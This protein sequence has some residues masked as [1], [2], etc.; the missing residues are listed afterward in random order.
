MKK[1]YLFALVLLAA[2]VFLPQVHAA[3]C[4]PDPDR[5]NCVWYDGG[6]YFFDNDCDCVLFEMD[7]CPYVY[8]PVEGGEGQPDGDGDGIGDACEEPEENLP[9]VIDMD[10]IYL[11]CIETQEID[12][13]AYDHEN[14]PLTWDV[15][16]DSDPQN[17]IM[18]LH[19]PWRVRSN[20][21]SGDAYIRVFVSDG[22]NPPV[23]ERLRVHVVCDVNAPPEAYQDLFVTLQCDDVHKRIDLNDYIRDPEYVTLQ[24][25]VGTPIPSGIVRKDTDSYNNIVYLTALNEGAAHFS[26]RASDGVNTEPFAMDVEVLAC[27]EASA[28]TIIFNDRLLACSQSHPVRLRDI[29]SDE[30]D[31]VEQMMGAGR[32]QVTYS[33]QYVHRQDDYVYNVVH[34]G[35]VPGGALP[36]SV[37]IRATNSRGKMTE[38][39]AT[40]TFDNCRPDLVIP[41]AVYDCGED[42]RVDSLHDYVTDEDPH[43]VTIAVDGYDA[44]RIT[45]P[46][47]VGD[48]LTF[49]TKTAGETGISFGLR[50]GEGKPNTA[51]FRFRVRE[52]AEPDNDPPEWISLDVPELECGGHG[53]VI[54]MAGNVRDDR[55]EFQ[56]LIFRASSDNPTRIRVTPAIIRPN[57]RDPAVAIFRIEHVGSNSASAH[58]V[59]TADDGIGRSSSIEKQVSVTCLA[60]NQPPT[61]DVSPDHLDLSCNGRDSFDIITGDPENDH[62]YVAVSETDPDNVIDYRWE[63][64][65]VDVI[66]RGRNGHASIIVRANDR[67]GGH[68]DVVKT[69]PVTVSGCGGGNNAPVW[70]QFT[71]PQISCGGQ[72]D[73]TIEPYMVSDETPFNRLR[74]SVES[75]DPD[76]TVEKIDDLTYRFFHVSG[77]SDSGYFRFTAIDEQGLSGTADK[78]VVA[79]CGFENHDPVLEYINPLHVS[80]NG[81]GTFDLFATDEDHDGLTFHVSQA[82][83]S[84]YVD[85]TFPYQQENRVRV[86]ALGRENTV[87][88]PVRVDD[89][90]GGSDSQDVYVYITCVSPP[91]NERPVWSPFTLQDISCEGEREIDIKPYVSDD[92]DSDSALRFFAESSRSDVRVTHDTQGVFVIEHVGD[93]DTSA[94]ITFRA[95]DT[96]GLDAFTTKSIQVSGCEDDDDEEDDI[97]LDIPDQS[98]CYGDRFAVVDLDDHVDYSWGD[99]D[100]SVSGEDDLDVHIDSRN[101]LEVDYPEGFIGSETLRFRVED[102]EDNVDSQDVRFRVRDCG[103]DILPPPIGP[104][105]FIPTIRF[106]EFKPTPEPNT[107]CIIQDRLTGR[108]LPD[109]DCDD[110][111]DDRDN[112]PDTPNTNQK[113]LNKNGIGDA[114]DLILSYFEVVPDW[115]R[116]GESF[117]VKVGIRNKFG[118]DLEDVK[119]TLRLEGLG[120]TQ[121][122]NIPSLMSGETEDLDFLVDISECT[123]AKTYTVKLS[124]DSR[125]RDVLIATGK[126]K[127]VEGKCFAENRN[128]NIVDLY[129]IQDVPAGGNALYPLRITNTDS[130]A[131]SY[132]LRLVGIDGWGGYSFD[133][134][135]VVVVPAN[136]EMTVNAHVYANSDAPSG[137][138]TFMAE[139]RHANEVEQVILGASVKS[140]EKSD[141]A[142]SIRILQIVLG[143]LVVA[144][145]VVGIAYLIAT[146]RTREQ[147]ARAYT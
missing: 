57:E 104:E 144:G 51:E 118:Y 116:A 145:I 4:I 95:L 46:R 74:F 20:G 61:L 88:I 132:T 135:S 12:L 100:F 105:P 39:T 146:R 127:V 44:S 33:S 10:P 141:L 9:P 54:I 131:K 42:V 14:D 115:V 103:Y 82:I 68:E 87:R 76:F 26:I 121:A 73:F 109:F 17:L 23:S 117:T 69:V 5:E 85:V 21:I 119:L 108:T 107:Q 64:S 66:A 138:K 50:D 89:G 101:R 55:T 37:T 124:I 15:V 84:G 40:F 6:Q 130:Y 128:V 13:N 79:R 3:A 63:G 94:T 125:A 43:E 134:G 62:V 45:V 111:P 67:I 56:D 24:Y 136:T 59:F 81:E 27:E 92:H 139:I 28:P 102:E 70:N 75:L 72:L 65:S 97:R 34:P 126:I 11:D 71:I 25:T 38:K 31:T 140:E 120:I 60:Q 47:I 137:E 96:G 16:E 53:E 49:Q 78:S 52:C 29:I 86:R 133:T 7:N 123:E 77:E 41:Y 58:L 129:N 110:V 114:C 1:I 99:L 30:Y 80:C 8:N 142:L 113:D 83:P 36:A 93:T 48:D 147:A 112:C 91:V 32:I 143:I 19:N 106:V 90:H 2:I 22:H 98:V 122:K 35:I 18:I